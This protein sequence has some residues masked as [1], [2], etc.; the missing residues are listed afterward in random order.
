MC[1]KKEL[2][3]VCETPLPTLVQLALGTM[4]FNGSW[5]VDRNDNYE[6][7]MEQMGE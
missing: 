7:F 1:F 6:K 3:S 5:K 4:T 2:Q